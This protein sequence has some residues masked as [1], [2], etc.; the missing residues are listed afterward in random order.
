MK[1]VTKR[2]RPLP[3]LGNTPEALITRTIEAPVTLL[4]TS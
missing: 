1:E 3:P 4:L 2:K